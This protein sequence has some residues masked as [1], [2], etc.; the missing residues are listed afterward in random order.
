MQVALVSG[1]TVLQDHVV[2]VPLTFA[3]VDTGACRLSAKVGH[4]TPSSG[5]FQHKNILL[6]RDLLTMVVHNLAEGAEVRARAA[7]SSSASSASRTPAPRA[8]DG[9]YTIT[10]FIYNE[11]YVEQDPYAVDTSS[12]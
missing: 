5:L 12:Y 9:H 1:Q 7:A 8:A 6:Q 4:E 11:P 3:Q 10:D 2:T